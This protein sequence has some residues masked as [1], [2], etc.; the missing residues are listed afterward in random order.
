MYKIGMSSC[1]FE[2]DEANF[3]SLSESKIECIEISM[4]YEKYKDINYKEVKTLSERYG[5]GL[6]SYHLPFWPFETLEISAFDKSIRDNTVSYF[7]ELIKMASDIG[8]DKFIVHPSG[9]PIP[10]SER[11]DRMKYSMQSLDSL[12]EIAHGCGSVIA[13]EDLPRTCLGN[14]SDDVLRLISANDKL[15]VCFDTNHLLSE[16]NINFMKKVGDKII[17]VHISD[18]DLVNER[19]WLPGEGRLDWKRMLATLKEIGYSGVW[20]YEIGLRCPKTLV[21]DRDLTFDD[22]YSNAQTIFE[23][24]DPDPIG[25]PSVAL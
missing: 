18:Y 12:A 3:K 10:D 21:R 23:G 24:K 1:G 7:S 22:F 6:W 2:L 13:V 14:T 19:H 15:R 9:E 8:I 17:T 5:V 25:R 11:D 20:M 16:D 4:S